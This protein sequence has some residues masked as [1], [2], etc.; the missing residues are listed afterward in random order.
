MEMTKKPKSR[1]VLVT[2][3]EPLLR[4]VDKAASTEN[5]NRSAEMCRR[6]D[7]SF[8]ATHAKVAT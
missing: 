3:P 8:R 4:K 7:Q 1:K 2:V 6:L 5:R